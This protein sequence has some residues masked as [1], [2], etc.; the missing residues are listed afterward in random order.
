VPGTALRKKLLNKSA[1]KHFFA[2]L[3]VHANK[4]CMSGS[5]KRSTPIV[6]DKTNLSFRLTLELLCIS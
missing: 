5:D 2:S 1:E 3:C 6:Y 4:D